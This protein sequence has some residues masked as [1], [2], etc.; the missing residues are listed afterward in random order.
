[1]HLQPACLTV[2]LMPARRLRQRGGRPD[3]LNLEGRLL[4]PLCAFEQLAKLVERLSACPLPGRSPARTAS[5][6]QL[7]LRRAL[8][9]CQWPSRHDEARIVLASRRKP[10]ALNLKAQISQVATP[11]SVE[12]KRT[13]SESGC[14]S[15]YIGGKARMP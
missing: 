9:L 7:R 2:W 1:M 15:T 6:L 13:L 14:F 12:V 10:Q 4:Q 8:L 5:R 11:E 3:K